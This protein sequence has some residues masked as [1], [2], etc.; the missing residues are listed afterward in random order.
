[1]TDGKQPAIGAEWTLAGARF[2]PDQLRFR[3]NQAPQLDPAAIVRGQEPAVQAE[4]HPGVADP[5]LPTADFF[6]LGKEVG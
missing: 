3:A 2:F 5:R 4:L 1:M 6:V